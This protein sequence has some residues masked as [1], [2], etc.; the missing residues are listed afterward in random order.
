MIGIRVD[1][2]RTIATGHIM[3]DISI[4]RKL[5]MLGADFMFISADEQCVPYLEKENFKYKI[6]NSSFENLNSEIEAM[7]DIIKEY[8]IH[9]LL[10]DTYYATKEYMEAL[11][12][13]TKVTYFDEMY[14][15]G[16][17][18]DQMI[19]G[20]IEPPD[21]SMAK[22]TAFLGPDYVPLREEFNNLPN[23][24]VNDRIEKI[25]VTSG[26]TDNYHFIK[27]FLTRFL[28]TPKWDE[29]KL[30]VVV[31]SLNVDKDW[32]I[33]KFSNNDRVKL[34]INT[35]EM[36]K[37]FQEADYA[38]SAGGTTLYEVC[39]T[40]VCASSY[41]LADN[42]LEIVQSF[43]RLGLISYAGDYRKDKDATINNIILQIEN[44][45]SADYRREKAARLQKIVDGNGAVR[46]AK[47]LL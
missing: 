5:K 26:G 39:A 45:K 37:L 9:S 18:C 41:A 21:Y 31:G 11:T 46:I 34:Y 16:F 47:L 22:G 13:L 1:V 36:A 33:S 25:L 4:A 38:L 29:V 12:K 19:N 2:N 24:P 15:L 27:E 40:G 43:D 3:R 6:L 44:A 20:V 7:S 8:D 10:V 42:Q 35:N 28:E 32:I 23:K 14:K 17:G 30:L